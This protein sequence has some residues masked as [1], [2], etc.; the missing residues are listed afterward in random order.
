MRRFSTLIW[1]MTAAAL[2]LMVAPAAMA[3]GNCCPD[4]GEGELAELDYGRSDVRWQVFAEHVRVHLTVSTPCG[5]FD[6]V[7]DK[8][9]LPAFSIAE[10]G[11]DDPNGQYTWQ[12]RIEEPVDP[13]VQKALK[14]ARES[15]DDRIVGELRR[16][17]LLP[18]GPFIQTGEFTVA[19]NV[20]VA[21]G[22]GEE[23]GAGL[24]VSQTSSVAAGETLGGPLSADRALAETVISGDLT[25]Y[26]S[27][28]VGFDCLANETYGADT[29]RLKENNLR[30]HVDDTSTA[31]GFPNQDWRLEFNSQASGGAE[32]F[33]VIDVTANRNIMTLEASAPSNSLVVDNGGRVGFGTANPVVELHVSNG[34]TPTLRLEQ[35]TSS[36]FAAQV[37]DV[38]GNESNFF[39]RDATNGSTLPFRI[40]PGA[41]SSQ[42]IIDDTNRIGMGTTSPSSAL[43]LR[44]TDGSAQALVEETS[45]T[46]ATRTL[47]R[48]SNNGGAG[49]ALVNSNSAQ[50]WRFDTGGADFNITLVG[51]GELAQ[52]D[53]SGN[54]T[55]DG[56]LTANGTNYPSSRSLK[57]NFAV[58]DPED[59]LNRLARVP[60]S[61]W[62]YKSDPA[63][64]HIGPVTEDFSSA[65]DFLEADGKL[66]TI[67]LHGVALAAIQGLSATMTT[68]L[69]KKDARIRELEER[70][71]ALETATLPEAPA[72]E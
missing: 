14:E 64:R 39:V 1:A 19:D 53:T 34:D 48:L 56:D 54:L 72:I 46:V 9:E 5:V 6:R 33:R 2:L 59:V 16:K 42:L 36:G 41:S 11:E 62:T 69:A 17:G 3:G 65:F 43:H 18:A 47:L 13:G 55:I 7:Y 49:F 30:I 20:I 27:L 63:R 32:Y 44:R 31:A 61:T 57:A 40:F 45:G 60:V 52:L 8:G 28:C 22:S 37:W 29:I 12:I 70:L 21:P 25:V 10:L 38:A 50:E 24:R 4:Q 15:G 26:N 58:V 68:E 35:N 67:D 51:T 71:L 23:K 66:N